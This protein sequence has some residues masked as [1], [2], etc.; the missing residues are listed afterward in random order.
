M[1]I[2]PER[3]NKSLLIGAIAAGAVVAGGLSWLLFSERAKMFTGR[4]KENMKDQARDLAASLLTEKT[5]VGKDITRPAADAI[6]S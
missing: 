5:G 3:K 1:K 2:L 4:V 6:I